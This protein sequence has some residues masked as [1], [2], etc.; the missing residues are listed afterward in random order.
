[1]I[2]TKSVYFYGSGTRAVNADS[3]D[4]TLQINTYRGARDIITVLSMDDTGPGSL[5]RSITRNN[6]RDSSGIDRLKG[7]EVADYTYN[8]NSAGQITT[9]SAYFYGTTDANAVR[10][11]DASP[12]DTTLQINTYRGARDINDPATGV[13]FIN[14]TG[15][16]SL[17]RRLH[18]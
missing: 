11:K 6:V 16:G 13:E 17:I 3:E 7:E 12:E 15:P 9:K 18:L 14:D 4:V 5:I 1:V 10:A 2:I 8:Y